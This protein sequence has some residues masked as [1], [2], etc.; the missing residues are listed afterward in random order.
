MLQL[1]NE[2]FQRISIKEN[3]SR[4]SNQYQKAET[5]Q[6]QQFCRTL[7]KTNSHKTKKPIPAKPKKPIPTKPKK[8]IPKKPKEPKKTIFR[9]SVKA[10]EISLPIKSPG[11]LFFLVFLVL[12]VLVFL[13]LWELV[14]WDYVFWFRC[15]SSP[16]EPCTHIQTHN[17]AGR[18]GC[19]LALQFEPISYRKMYIICYPPPP[20]PPRPAPL[21]NLGFVHFCRKDVILS[22]FG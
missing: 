11:K 12:L 1:Q 4:Q 22:C 6:Q 3:S 18:F 14:F 17:L 21:L 10:L 5:T 13:V 7:R 8:P 16:Y 15:P 9:D 20:P 19:L 2:T